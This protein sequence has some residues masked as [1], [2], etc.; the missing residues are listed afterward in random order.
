MKFIKMIVT[1]QLDSKGA[2]RFARM[3]GAA[4]VVAA[5]MGGM[6]ALI[7]AVRWW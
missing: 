2:D 4:Y 3:V 7:W 5:V 1:G 6:A